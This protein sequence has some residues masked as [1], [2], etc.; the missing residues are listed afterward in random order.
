MAGEK[1][2]SRMTN[3]QKLTTQQLTFVSR[4]RTV[5]QGIMIEICTKEKLPYDIP[6]VYCEKTVS[7]QDLMNKKKK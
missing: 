2:A 7:S 1:L 3:S 5:Y 6:I 4:A